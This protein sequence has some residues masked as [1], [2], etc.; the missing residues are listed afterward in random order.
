M[1]K[2]LKAA[3][4]RF[5]DLQPSQIHNPHVVMCK[6]HLTNWHKYS[7]LKVKEIRW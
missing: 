1:I 5:Q 4:E 2:C 6:V 7:I 3:Y